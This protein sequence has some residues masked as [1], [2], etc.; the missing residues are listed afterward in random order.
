[1]TMEDPKYI[2]I[3][4]YLIDEMYIFPSVV[5]HQNFVFRNLW[6]EEDVISAGFV[7]MESRRC[8]GVSTSLNKKSRPDEDS[9]ILVRLFFKD[10]P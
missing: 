1:V 5:S 9:D 6:S 2:V 7:N 8:Y 10:E 4:G 3:D